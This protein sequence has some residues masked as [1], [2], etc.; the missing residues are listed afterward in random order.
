VS[1]EEMVEREAVEIVAA[2]MRELGFIEEDVLAY[3]ANPND[4]DDA[5][6]TQAVETAIRTHAASM[7]D[8]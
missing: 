6:A 3:I 7:R 1:R 2:T 5:V 4:G 8:R